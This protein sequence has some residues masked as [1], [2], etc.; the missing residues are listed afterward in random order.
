MD[1][2]NISTLDRPNGSMRNSHYVSNRAPLKPSAFIKLPVGAVRP[3][4]WLLEV[5]KRQNSGLA[6]H[7]G[8]I[9]VWLQKQGN[10]WLDPNGEGEWGWEELPY[11]LKGYANTGY[12]L[13]DDQV[14]AESKIWIEGALNSQ[15][16]DGDFGPAIGEHPKRD[17]WGNMIMLYCLQSYHE[18]TQDSRVITLMTNYFRFQLSVPD[19]AFLNGYWQKVRG[20]DNLESVFW[21]YNRTGDSWL[22]DLAKK[23]HRCSSDWTAPTHNFE[24][25]RNAK[26]KRDGVDWPDWFLE[27]V[28]WHNVNIAQ[29]FREPAQFHLVS[30]EEKHL[31]ATYRNFATVRERFGQVPGGMFGGD[32]NSRPGYDDPRQG[33]ETCAIVEQLN[34]DQ[35]LLRITGDPFWADHA[36]EVAFNTFPAAMM[37]DMRS[38]RYVTSPNMVLCDAESHH[39]GIDN[40]GPML[41]MNP[42]SSRCCQHNHTQGWPYY[43]ENCWMATP[44]NGLLAAL[45]VASEVTAT[46]GDDGKSVTI[47][48]ETNY[49]F[50]ERIRFRISSGCGTFPLYLR[51][52]SW[53]EDA[54]VRIN[55]ADVDETMAP[56]KYVRIERDWEVADTVELELPM[57]LRA[58][59]WERNHGSVSISHGPLTFSLRIGEKYVKRESDQTAIQDS[60]WQDGADRASWPSYEIHPDS[61]W[62]Y[63]LMYDSESLESCFRIELKEWP[64][65]NFPFTL[66]EVPIKLVATGKRIPEWTID[67]T[68]LCGELQDSP[69]LSDQPVEEIELVPMGAARLRISAFPVIGEGEN[70]IRWKPSRAT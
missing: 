27:L 43:T 61:S 41:I 35:H 1:A 57:R 6:R 10:A 12:I 38:L 50:E 51:I 60:R 36:E 9:S 18:Y 54:Q 42:F 56:G 45:Y 46:V 34:S 28:D 24:D 20:G 70:A 68:G 58:K 63:G 53:C 59:V 67:E 40:G 26:S 33:I 19:E 22:L 48:E 47:V 37:P 4:G 2:T 55:D 8:E 25:I 14:I 21:L 30:G 17:F 5:L 69:V 52:P 32:E 64:A 66:N 39:P 3:R 15:R 11:W 23:I 16:T 65:S 13:G 29:A 31:H 49:P 7:L 62:N 44:D